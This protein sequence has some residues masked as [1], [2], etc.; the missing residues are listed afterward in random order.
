M[1]K[2]E[3]EKLHVYDNKVDMIGKEIDKIKAMDIKDMV[4]ELVDDG[5]E[6][7]FVKTKLSDRASSFL[8]EKGRYFLA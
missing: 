1:V 8:N 4:L 7:K 5:G 2:K 3:N 6:R